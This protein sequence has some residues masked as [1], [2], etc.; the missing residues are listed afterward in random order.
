MIHGAEAALAHVLAMLEAGGLIS[1]EGKLL[2]TRIASICVHGD[3]P[4]AVATAQALRNGLQAAGWQL[5]GLA[6]LV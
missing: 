5:G 2:P 6:A 1:R 3:G 4:E